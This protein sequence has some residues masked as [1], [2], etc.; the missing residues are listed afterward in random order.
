PNGYRQASALL[1]AIVGAARGAT[2]SAEV[3]PH[4]RV[5][6]PAMTTSQAGRQPPYGLSTARHAPGFARL[7][8]R[9]TA[10]RY[11]SAERADSAPCPFVSVGAHASLPHS[12][13][14]RETAGRLRSR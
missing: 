11:F 13:P 1:Y 4:A 14:R 7:Q 12:L 3:R 5:G 10:R 9:R 6:G 2:R 8:A